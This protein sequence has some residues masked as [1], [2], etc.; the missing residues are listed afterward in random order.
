MIFLICLPY[1]RK[2]FEHLLGSSSRSRLKIL[3]TSTQYI[4]HETSQAQE[5]KHW[6]DLILE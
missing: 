6:L 3:T 5:L 4:I 1:Y 2:G